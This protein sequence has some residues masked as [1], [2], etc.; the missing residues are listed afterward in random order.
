M[1]YYLFQ[2]LKIVLNYKIY[3]SLI[4]KEHMLYM[5]DSENKFSLA[6]FM[7][8]SLLLLLK[9][10]EQL[11]AYFWASSF[12]SQTLSLDALSNFM[13]SK[14]GLFVTLPGLS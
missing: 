1:L 8:V 4:K 14:H 13:A 2:V 10:V 9:I 6:L 7:L 3:C 12:L 5:N 11:S